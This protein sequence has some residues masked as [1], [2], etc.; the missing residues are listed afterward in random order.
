[1]LRHLL[2]LLLW[3]LQIKADL[4]VEAVSVPVESSEKEPEEASLSG[5]CFRFPAA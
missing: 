2:K 5:Y 1:L 3:L 4:L